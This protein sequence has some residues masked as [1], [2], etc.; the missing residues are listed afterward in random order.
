MI[1]KATPDDLP[2]VI[3]LGRAFQAY[4]PYRNLPFDDEAFGEFCAGVMEAGVIFLSEDGFL[5]GLLN[6]MYFNPSVIMAVELF[7][8]AGSTG[9]Q[10]RQAFE[11]W[12]QENGAQGCQFTGLADE[13][14]P[15]IR[16]VFA[17]AG[18]RACEVAFMKEF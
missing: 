8:W 6:P 2:R 17:R 9:R 12:A 11:E 13:R 18:Y 15:T 7:W 14:E 3:E 1:R 10:L 5:G 4:S 16:K